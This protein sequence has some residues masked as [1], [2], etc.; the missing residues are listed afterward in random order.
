MK[1]CVFDNIFKIFSNQNLFWSYLYFFQT[2]KTNT[3]KTAPN[4]KK[5]IKY[6][7]LGFKFCIHQ[8]VCVLNFLLKKSNLLQSNAHPH[9]HYSN[10]SG[11]CNKVC[12]VDF[13]LISQFFHAPKHL[14]NFILIYYTY[15]K[16]NQRRCISFLIRPFCL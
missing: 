14:V 4:I 7:C 5:L 10:A 1:F 9:K 3:Q 8:R 13:L 6:M 12:K 16:K 15:V 2:L 11:T